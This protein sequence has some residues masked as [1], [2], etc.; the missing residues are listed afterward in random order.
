MGAHQYGVSNTPTAEKPLRRRDLTGFIIFGAILVDQAASACDRA[1]QD[2]IRVAAAAR[3]IV[4]AI[5]DW[6]GFLM[7][8]RDQMASYQANA[9]STYGWW[10][11]GDA[12]MIYGAYLLANQ[13]GIFIGIGVALIA[14]SAAAHVARFMWPMRTWAAYKMEQHDQ[15]RLKEQGAA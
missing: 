12:S 15:A 10:L 3:N 11:I 5:H 7:M 14:H 4:V 2:A 6:E 13:A 9:H 1:A 8:F